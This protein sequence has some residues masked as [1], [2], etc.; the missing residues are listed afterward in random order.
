MRVPPCQRILSP[1]SKIAPGGEGG[2][3]EGGGDV[4]HLRDGHGNWG[5]TVHIHRAMRGPSMNLMSSVSCSSTSKAY[6]AE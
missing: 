3:V 4:C 1:F 6:C 2:V 5:S